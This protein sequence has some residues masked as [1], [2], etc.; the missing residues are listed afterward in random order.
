MRVIKHRWDAELVLFRLRGITQ[1]FLR[2]ETLTDLILSQ[3]ASLDDNTAHRGDIFCVQRLQLGD[4]IQD[5][6]K[7]LPV[8]GL[9]TLGEVQPGKMSNMFDFFDG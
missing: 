8:E 9:F 1:E 6:G 5:A 4:V 7:L 3:G 2:F